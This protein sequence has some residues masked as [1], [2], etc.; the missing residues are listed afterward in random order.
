MTV[1]WRISLSASHHQ[2]PSGSTSICSDVSSQTG[3]SLSGT[4][5]ALPMSPRN[6]CRSHQPLARNLNLLFGQ[7]FWFD[8]IRAGVWQPN[9]WV[10]G[11]SCQWVGSS[12]P[13]HWDKSS[14]YP[15]A[16]PTGQTSLHR[17]DQD[18]PRFIFDLCR[19]NKK[20]TIS[21]FT[22]YLWNNYNKKYFWKMNVKAQ[23][24]LNLLVM[25]LT[26]GRYDP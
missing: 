23:Q 8:W 15:A 25:S 26:L 21:L 17:F 2:P 4:K 11:A 9:L 24:N 22:P 1:L 13:K 18:R 16:P 5:P 12:L 19:R 10:C 6:S 7:N 14:S 3:S 20:S